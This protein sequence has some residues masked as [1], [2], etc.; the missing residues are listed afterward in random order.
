MRDEHA[1]H[2]A[3][4]F[5]EWRAESALSIAM[6]GPTAHGVQIGAGYRVDHRLRTDPALVTR[7][8]ELSALTAGG[9]AGSCSNAARTASGRRTTSRC[10]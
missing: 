2:L 7:S 8:P 4:A 9:C 10:R 3:R 1:A 6:S 5:D